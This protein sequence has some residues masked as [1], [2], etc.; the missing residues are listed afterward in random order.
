GN[1]ATHANRSETLRRLVEGNDRLRPHA[2]AWPAID[3]AMGV[4][5]EIFV[6]HRLLE[7]GWAFDSDLFRF[8]RTLVRAAQELPQ[9]AGQ[10]LREAG[11]ARMAEVRNE[12]LAPAPVHPELEIETLAWSLGWMRSELGAEDPFVRGFFGRRSPRE[13]AEEAVRGTHLGDADVRARL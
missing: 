6:P 11:E 3:R 7:E 10:R 13:I 1:L 5:R 8:A 2:A 9:P 12:P 4:A